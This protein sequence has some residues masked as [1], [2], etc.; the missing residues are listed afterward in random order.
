MREKS[1]QSKGGKAVFERM[2]S[3]LICTARDE[4]R[5]WGERDS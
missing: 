4:R 1:M 2:L 3:A 5:A